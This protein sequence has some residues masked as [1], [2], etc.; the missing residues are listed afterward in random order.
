MHQEGGGQQFPQLGKS[1]QNTAVQSMPACVPLPNSPVSC[2][3]IQ[4]I[5]NYHKYQSFWA[6]DNIYI[7]NA[8]SQLL[9][10]YCTIEGLLC[11]KVE[12]NYLICLKQHQ[13]WNVVVHKN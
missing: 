10:H 3:K 8:L 5:R 12:V 4:H 11:N 2:F 1:C 6:L 13:T 9:S 7:N